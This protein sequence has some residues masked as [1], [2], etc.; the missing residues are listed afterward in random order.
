MKMGVLYQHVEVQQN[1]FPAAEGL[2]NITVLK[3]QITVK[4]IKIQQ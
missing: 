1:Y 2:G 4:P 3:K